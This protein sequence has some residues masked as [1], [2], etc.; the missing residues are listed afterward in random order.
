MFASKMLHSQ[1]SESATPVISVTPALYFI[2]KKNK[3]LLHFVYPRVHKS[4]QERMREL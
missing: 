2:Q 3:L 1:N 4:F